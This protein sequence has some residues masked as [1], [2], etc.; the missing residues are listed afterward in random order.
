MVRTKACSGTGRV[1]AEKAPRKNFAAA[2]SRIDLGS[3]S[4]KKDKYAGGNPVCPRPT[5]NWQKPIDRFFIM[6]TTPNIVNSSDKT[7]AIVEKENINPGSSTKDNN[8]PTKRKLQTEEESAPGP[9]GS[10]KAA[11]GAVVTMSDEISE[12]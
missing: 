11:N 8:S 10:K 9:S 5:P 4:S 2:S 1:T 3:P 6:N 12:D 7:D